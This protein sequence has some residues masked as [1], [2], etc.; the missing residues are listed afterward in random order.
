MFESSQAFSVL[1]LA[2]TSGQNRDPTVYAK[3]FAR[4]ALK[5]QVD[6]A[7]LLC[8]FTRLEPIARSKASATG[9]SNLDAWASTVRHVTSRASLKA[10][11]PID[12]LAPVLQD[13]AAFVASSSGVEQSFTKGQ[14]AFTDR[15]GKASAAVEENSLKLVLDPDPLEDRHICRG[16]RFVFGK[17][18]GAE[19]RRDSSTQAPLNKGVSKAVTADSTSTETAFL[20]HRRQ[21]FAAVGNTAT[22][23]VGAAWD[24]KHEAEMVFAQRKLEKRRRQACHEDLLLKEEQ[25]DELLAATQAERKRQRDEA[26]TRE[27]VHKRCKQRAVGASFDVAWLHGRG[28]FVDPCVQMT[29]ELRCALDSC[30]MEMADLHMARAVVVPSATECKLLHRCVAI[31]RGGYVVTAESITHPKPESYCMKYKPAMG[32]A[33]KVYVSEAFKLQ[34]SNI[35]RMI[36][37]VHRGL[38]GRSKWEFIS[39]ETLLKLRKRNAKTRALTG[40]VT[41]GEKTTDQDCRCFNN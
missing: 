8:Q 34:H 12:A 26:E 29:H 14:W 3:H 25:S 22:Y 5:A 4:L 17:V 9:V 10:S 32:R 13:Y 11:Y 31:L 27:R 37:R 28:V 38:Y 20:R 41:S 1:S 18:F 36:Q 30:D 23:D 16:A 40:L 39:K 19:R 6:E 33:R 2:A 15:Q 35:W 24:A 7:A 21:T